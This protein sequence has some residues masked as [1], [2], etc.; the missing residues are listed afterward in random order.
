MVAICVKLD[1]RVSAP[2]RFVHPPCR[3]FNASGAV[4][5]GMTPRCHCKSTR[6][7]IPSKSDNIHAH[8]RLS[9]SHPSRSRFNEPFNKST[10]HLQVSRRCQ[11][12][13]SCRV[14]SPSVVAFRLVLNPRDKDVPCPVR[15]WSCCALSPLRIRRHPLRPRYQRVK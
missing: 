6:G 2:L 9:P 12:S 1:S 13:T 11:H 4:L 5:I 7:F 3:V 8:N 10:W 15:A 14:E